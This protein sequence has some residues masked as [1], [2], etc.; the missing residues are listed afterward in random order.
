M[1]Y[2]PVTPGEMYLAAMGGD[3]GNVTITGNA[4]DAVW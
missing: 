4:T 2:Q 3:A 1:K